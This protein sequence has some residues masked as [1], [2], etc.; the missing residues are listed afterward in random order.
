MNTENINEQELKEEQ[1][2]EE[3]LNDATGGLLFN[4]DSTTNLTLTKNNKGI[5]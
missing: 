5:L 3:Q 2:K 4:G 1:L